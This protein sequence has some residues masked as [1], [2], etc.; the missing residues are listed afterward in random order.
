MADRGL[1]D[2]LRIAGITCAEG[3]EMTRDALAGLGLSSE[4]TDE[5]LT[6]VSELIANARRHAG[7]VTAFEVTARPGTVVVEVC[8]RSPQ[9]PQTRP[10]A[11]E[12]PGASGGGWSTS[13]P[14]RPTSISGAATRP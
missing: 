4:R 5:V 7:G 10:W 11:P 8:D 3:R 2:V 9:L 1:S 12:Q 6:V 14:M 13:L